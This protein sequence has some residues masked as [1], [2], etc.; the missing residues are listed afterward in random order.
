MQPA[1]IH[2]R[3]STRRQDADNHLQILQTWAKQRGLRVV[4]V[5]EKVESAWRDGH[6]GLRTESAVKNDRP[7]SP[8][9]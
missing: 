4:A 7:D 5:Y 1:V 8:C 2:S 3:V 9:I 6:Q